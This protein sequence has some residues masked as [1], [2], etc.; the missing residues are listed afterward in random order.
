MP[1]NLTVNVLER[2]HSATGRTNRKRR[3]LL[4]ID[5]HPRELGIGIVRV[6]QGYIRSVAEVRLGTVDLLQDHMLLEASLGGVLAQMKTGQLTLG[7]HDDV[8]P[9]G[10]VD[11]I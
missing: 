9:V 3:A 5:R 10:V 8:V 2:L 4:A 6:L 11:S 7:K 1:H